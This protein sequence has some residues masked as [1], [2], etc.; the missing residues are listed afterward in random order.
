MEIDDLNLKPGTLRKGILALAAAAAAIIILAGTFFTVKANER[1]VLFTF[2]RA[3]RVLMPGM[4]AKIPFVQTKEKISIVPQEIMLKINVGDD[5]AVSSDM[6]EIGVTAVVNY[7]YDEDSLLDIAKNYTDKKV[8]DLIR[9]AFINSV[10]SVI[11]KYTIYTLVQNADTI[12][13]TVQDGTAAILAES[14]IPVTLVQLTLDNW[15][16][17]N[18]FNEQVAETMKK[19]Q[20]VEQA[21][22]DLAITEQTSQKQVKEAEANRDK[23]KLDGEAAVIEAQKNAEAKKAEADGIA[24]YNQKVSQNYSVQQ[25]QWKHEEEMKYYEKWDGKLVPA[26]MWSSVP[27]MSGTILGEKK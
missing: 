17:P 2:G 16:W 5:A 23:A 8:H 4:H 27:V 6:Q 3:E 10:K 19:K 9:N 21:K 14:R 26:Q 7:R 12:R 13:G 18:S 24:Y 20:Q 15:N 11:G 1:A 22:Q 25:S